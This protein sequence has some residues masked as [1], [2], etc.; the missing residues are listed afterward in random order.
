MEN[1]PLKLAVPN[2]DKIGM[3]IH[4][5]EKDS[6]FQEC[7]YC[8]VF[9]MFGCFPIY[10]T[11]KFFN[12]PLDRLNFFLYATVSIL[13]LLL[14]SLLIKIFKNKD[15]IIIQVII[16]KIFNSFKTFSITDYAMIAFLICCILSTAFSKY[17]K[18]SFIGQF[19]RDNGLL[20]YILYFSAY[21]L[22]SRGFKYQNSVFTILMLTSSCMFLMAILQHLGFD[23][24]GFYQR[25]AFDQQSSYLST[26]GN[27]NFF[28]SFVVLVMPIPTCLYFLCKSKTFRILYYI[29]MQLS[30][31]GLIVANSD[32][33]ILGLSALFVLLLFYCFINIGTLKR[34]CEIVIA[35]LFSI[36]LLSFLVALRPDQSHKFRGIYKVAMSSNW[37]NILLI[38]TVCV[39]FFLYF[40]SKTQLKSVNLLKR[41]K[42]IVLLLVCCTAIFLIL[43]FIWFTFIDT[44]TNIGELASYLRFNNDWGSHRGEIWF[45]GISAFNHL[46][47]FQK[48]F[49]YGMDMFAPI[50]S[51]EILFGFRV[52]T[53]HNEFLE[54][55][56]T[57]GICGLLSYFLFTL[58]QIIKCFKNLKHNPILLVLMASIICYLAQSIGNFATT[59]VTPLFMIM[60]AIAESI[61]R[62]I[63]YNQK[64]SG[65]I[66]RNFNKI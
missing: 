37:I 7:V 5:D 61:N 46:N 1:N 27:I 10:C 12:I 2:K 64:S 24:L 13:L 62:R 63:K 42:C 29:A 22:I 35:F 32:T 33:G 20:I 39:W 18:E 25:I 43:N 34:Y 49:G 50:I 65:I 45:T 47:I 44:K 8:F 30:F 28:S 14:V 57:T 26:I 54:Y 23:I 48:L 16:K 3:H 59:M 36:K 6:F 31:C 15:T 11:N 9:I 19:G 66:I 21:F 58:S 40:I 17:P 51:N 4:K 52:D 53:A 38:F 60:I 55:L 56:L 41:L